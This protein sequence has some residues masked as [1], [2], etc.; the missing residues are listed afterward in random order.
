MPS[1]TIN[2]IGASLV[3]SGLFIVVRKIIETSIADL[4]IKHFAR[5]GSEI[6]RNPKTEHKYREG[7]WKLFIHAWIV[8]YGL[9]ALLPS[10][11]LYDS[12]QLWIDALSHKMTPVYY[13]YYMI[14]LGYYFSEVLTHCVAVKRKDFIIMLLHHVVTILLIVTSYHNNLFRVGML[15]MLFHD[16]MDPFL[17]L[18]KIGKYLKLQ[19]FSYLMFFLLTI[20]YFYTRYVV[21]CTHSS[22][23]SIYLQKFIKHFFALFFFSF[24]VFKAISERLSLVAC[25]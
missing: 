12:Q 8:L 16:L 9:I 2:E 14:E 7:C 22:A 25:V 10:E 20:T 13:W 15:M 4:A 19:K 5:P 6:L 23:L 3:F 24:S 1:F 21:H 17:E 11:F 18:A